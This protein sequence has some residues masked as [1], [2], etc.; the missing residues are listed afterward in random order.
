MAIFLLL[1]TTIFQLGVSVELNINKAE[2]GKKPSKIKII[3]RRYKEN[4]YN[5][6]TISI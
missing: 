1:I 4:Q 3:H 2:V 5:L 6:K